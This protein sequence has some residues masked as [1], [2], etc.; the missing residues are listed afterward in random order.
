MI[1][2]LNNRDK[3]EVQNILNVQ[4]LAYQVEANLIEFDGI[5]QLN[6]TVDSIMGSNETF[7]GYKYERELAGFI[8]YEALEDELDIC[9]LVVHPNYFRKGIASKLLNYVM[10]EN[11]EV[12]RFTVSTGSKNIPAISL[13]ERFGFT[14]Y[15]KVEV[16]TGIY[17]TLLEKIT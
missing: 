7:I 13:Y 5:P 11:S 10:S 12:N 17:I 9:R 4:L 16:A 3:S 2:K 1:V 6:D 14:P 8:S 15:Q